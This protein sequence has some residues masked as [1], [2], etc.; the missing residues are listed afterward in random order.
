MEEL[1]P[2]IP[3]SWSGLGNTQDLVRLL[4]QHVIALEARV[5]ELEA[6]GRHATTYAQRLPSP[7][8]SSHVDK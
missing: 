4:T 3:N 7:W 5:A 6:N 2:T 1:D 8:L